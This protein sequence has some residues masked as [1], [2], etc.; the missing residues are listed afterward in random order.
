MSTLRRGRPTVNAEWN[1]PSSVLVG[2]FIYSRAFQILVQIGNMRIMEIIADTTNKIAEGEV[3][4]LIAK[5][6]PE[7]SEASYMQVIESKTAILFQAAAQCGALLG[8]A[9]PNIESAL[10]EFGLRIGTA[11]QL[12]DD[13]LDYAGDAADLGKNIGDD[14]AEGKVTLPLIHA[15]ETGTDPEKDLIREALKTEGLPKQMLQ[16]V[17]RIVR[18]NGGL[19]YTKNQANIHAQAAQKCLASLPESQFRHAMKAMVDFSINRR[20]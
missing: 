1:T 17:I 9:E 6:N 13:V 3:L 16:D 2:D 15:L 8:N 7:S 14:L 11:F 20:S 10:T 18:N 19:E 4:Q 5:N 12:V